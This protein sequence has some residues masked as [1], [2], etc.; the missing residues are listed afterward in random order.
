MN[1][2]CYIGGGVLVLL[3]SFYIS[4]FLASTF[5]ENYHE[6]LKHFK[7]TYRKLFILGSMLMWIW[8]CWTFV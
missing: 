8:I 2:L 5:V 7:I 1:W 6:E 3:L 4:T